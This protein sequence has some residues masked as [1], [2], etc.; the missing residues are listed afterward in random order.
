M[1]QEK[2]TTILMQ[3]FGVT[4]IEHYGVLWYFLEWSIVPVLWVS[5]VTQL[6]R[7]DL[8]TAGAQ[9]PLFEPVKSKKNGK[10]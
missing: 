5:Q 8:I 1:A 4:K 9:F 2:L 6:E 10:G 3:N 7:Q